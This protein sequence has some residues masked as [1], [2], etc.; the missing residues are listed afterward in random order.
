MNDTDDASLLAA[1]ARGDAS[2]FAVFLGRHQAAVYRYA[3]LL[4]HDHADAEEATQDAFVSAWRAADSF[5][6]TG[7][8]RSWLLAIARRAALR[9]RRGRRDE[10]TDAETLEQLAD[11][12]GWGDAATD[13]GASTS[14]QLAAALDRLSE[15]ERRALVLRDVEGLTP[16]VAAEQ[17]GLSVAAY[18][19]RL[20]RARLKL[21]AML[22]EETV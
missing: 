14:E 7:S 19:S 17:L 13:G 3:R 1:T 15:A 9:L 21:A 8:A 12:A 5:L 6:G 4:T 18:K 20:H 10:P 22:R 16:D 2:A 11:R